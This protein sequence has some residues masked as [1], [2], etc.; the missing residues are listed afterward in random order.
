MANVLWFYP[1]QG[2]MRVYGGVRGNCEAL[3]SVAED[4]SADAPKGG[5]RAFAILKYSL[6]LPLSAVADTVTLPVTI[7]CSLWYQATHP[8]P[9][10]DGPQT[11]PSREK[12]DPQE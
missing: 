12:T 10:G 5:D 3:Q 11:L 1:E 6:D 9:I 8:E 7:P 2:G 4:K